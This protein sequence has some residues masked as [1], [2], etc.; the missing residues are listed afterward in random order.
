MLSTAHSYKG[1]GFPWYCI[2][3][4]SIKFSFNFYFNSNVNNDV[5]DAFFPFLFHPIYMLVCSLFKVHTPRK[6]EKKMQQKARNVVEVYLDKLE[7]KNSHGFQKKI[8][9]K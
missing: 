4:N 3:F 2:Q 1:R 6:L 8:S 5:C 9:L 7:Q